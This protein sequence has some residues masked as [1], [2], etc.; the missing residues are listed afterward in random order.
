MRTV[1]SPQVGETQTFHTRRGELRLRMD[2]SNLL[3]E[4]HPCEGIV[5][6]LLQGLALIKVD[7]QLLRIC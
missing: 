5:D 1:V 3:V 2:H 6:A 4:R 7:G